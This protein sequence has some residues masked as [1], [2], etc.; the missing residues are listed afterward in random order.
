MLTNLDQVLK[1][2]SQDVVSKETSFFW[3]LFREIEDKKEKKD[4]IIKIKQEI[5]REPHDTIEKRNNLIDLP[6]EKKG[7]IENSPIPLHI[8]KFPVYLTNFI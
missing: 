1:A 4:N 5:F 6:L 3:T 7:L 8:S 2:S